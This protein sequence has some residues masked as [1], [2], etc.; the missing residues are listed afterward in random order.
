MTP[1]RIDYFSDILCV[2][3]YIA[4]VRLEELHSTFQD[5]V[6]I[7][8]HFVTIF[9]NARP[10]LE[11]RWKDKGGMHGY[12]RHVRETAAAHPHVQVHPD[13]WV[14]DTP[15][16]SL[17]CHL[18]LCAL[19]VQERSERASTDDGA[20]GFAAMAW[21]LRKAF[22]TEL[23]DISRRQVQMEIAE[24]HGLEPG[25]I[26]RA[27]DDGSAHAELARDLDLVRE[28]HVT[29]SPTMIF[30]EGRQ[31]LNGNVGYRVI[32]AN[33]RELLRSPEGEHSWC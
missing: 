17:S 1:I 30:N 19:R 22:F 12:S 8:H 10:R 9:G 4:Q 7:D 24:R 26:E 32:E 31:R 20:G 13:I 21:A 23:A 29:V 14:V 2:W 27:L 5:Q 16:S 18:F 11:A 25:P 15:T 6:A 33:V 3:A 28:H